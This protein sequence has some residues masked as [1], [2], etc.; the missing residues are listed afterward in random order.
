MQTI[1]DTYRELNR[2]LHATR[3]DMYGAN[4][5]RWADMVLSLRDEAQANTVLDYGCGKGKLK[6]ALGDPGWM[7]EYDPAIAGKDGEPEK[8]D[9]IVCTDVLEHIEPEFLDNVLDQIGKL[10]ERAVF[11]V[12]ATQPAEKHLADGRNAHLSLHDPQWWKQKLSDKFFIS[13][14]SATKT[15]VQMAGSPIMGLPV[16]IARSAVSETIRYEQAL[17]NC[18]LVGARVRK[19][20]RNEERLVLVCYGPSL[21]HTWHDIKLEKRLGAK[22]CSTSGAHDFLIERGIVP[23]YHVEVDP[24]EHKAFFT[25]NPHPDVNYWIASCCHPT[26]IDQLLPHKLAL[27][28]VYNSE[29][30]R[31]IIA[32]NGIDPGNW[33]ISGG[34]TVGCRAINV[35]FMAGYRSFSVY[36]MDCS[37][38][39]EGEQH[40]GVHTG[41]KQNEWM[42]RVGKRWFKTSGNLVFTARGFMQNM[43]VMNSCAVVNDEPCIPGTNDRVELFLHGDGFLS[44]LWLTS[45]R[46]NEEEKRIAA[47]E[48]A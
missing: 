18:P 35:M 48:A 5:Y 9:L 30:D 43:R 34:G 19:Q 8:A 21:K 31:N 13:S 26:L 17:R 10:A 44:E 23:D 16:I 14:W 40:A 2:D 28:H 38:D 33:L 47:A 20:P 46:Q 24:R 3:G 45:M 36:G 22:I 42:V 6:E 27:W 41:K 25:R 15:E 1:S 7:R 32:P 11:L 4:S 37:F 29:T 39:H 12:I